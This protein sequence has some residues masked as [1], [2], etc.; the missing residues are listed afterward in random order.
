M[1]K[2]VQ[3]LAS[4]R[5]ERLNIFLRGCQKEQNFSKIGKRGMRMK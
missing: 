4:R 1:R 2:E 5:T 3:F